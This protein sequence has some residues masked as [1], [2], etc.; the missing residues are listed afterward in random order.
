MKLGVLEDVNPV[1]TYTNA[2]IR[3]NLLSLQFQN[4]ASK[5]ASTKAI[6]YFLICV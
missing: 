6:Y 4:P 5:M 1:I 3:L 2:Y